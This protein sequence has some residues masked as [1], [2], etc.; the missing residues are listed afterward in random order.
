MYVPT[1]DGAV[2]LANVLT[3]RSGGVYTVVIQPNVTD[4]TSVRFSASFT[5]HLSIC[6]SGLERAKSPG[7]WM[8]T[9]VVTAAAG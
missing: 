7:V 9:R 3:V 2:E 5:F 4:P 8:W 6:C 1:S